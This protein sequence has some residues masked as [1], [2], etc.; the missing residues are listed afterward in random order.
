[1]AKIYKVTQRVNWGRDFKSRSDRVLKLY[2]STL[3]FAEFPVWIP[4]GAVHVIGT[5]KI[6]NT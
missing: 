3:V 2:F 6:K 1:M 4:F 5:R